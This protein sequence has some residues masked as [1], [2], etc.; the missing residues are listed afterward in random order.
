M[1]FVELPYVLATEEAERIGVDHVARV[2]TSDSGESSH[3]NYSCS[4]FNIPASF[5]SSITPFSSFPSSCINSFLFF[6]FI[7]R[8]EIYD[9]YVGILNTETLAFTSIQSNCLH[10]YFVTI[11]FFNYTCYHTSY[12]P[13]AISPCIFKT[14]ICSMPS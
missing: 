4:L 10:E 7:G 2:S 12:P 3:G 14:P 9:E 8:H 11:T 1:R 13:D 6:S 5:H